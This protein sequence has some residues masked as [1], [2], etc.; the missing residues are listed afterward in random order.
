MLREAESDVEGHT[1]SLSHPAANSLMANSSLKTHETIGK[2]LIKPVSETTDFGTPRYHHYNDL[3][4]TYELEQS[5]NFQRHGFDHHNEEGTSAGC[6][7]LEESLKYEQE[8]SIGRIGLEEGVE[9]RHFPL[10]GFT[11]SVETPSDQFY[12][13][14]KSKGRREGGK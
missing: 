9:T 14:V 5:A 3:G 8:H 13:P 4:R 12:S 11:G 10:T 7:Q 2:N 1:P 6:G